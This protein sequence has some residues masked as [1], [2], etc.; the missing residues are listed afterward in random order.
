MRIW[1]L[2]RKDI[3]NKVLMENCTN[4]VCYLYCVVVNIEKLHFL[5]EKILKKTKVISLYNNKVI[6][7]QVGKKPSSIL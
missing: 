3:L 5:I 7:K 1:I 4:T 6:K 2:I